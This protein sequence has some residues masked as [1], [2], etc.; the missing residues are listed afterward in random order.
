MKQCNVCGE[1]KETHLFSSCQSSK[2]KLR[3]SCKACTVK[4]TQ[5]RQKTLK[6]LVKKI[7]HNQK[8]TTG[9]MGREAPSYTEVELLN[10]ML[11]NGYEALWKVWAESGYDKWLSPSIDRIDNTKS[12]SLTNIQLVTWRKNLENQKEQNKSGKY[13][14]TKSKAVNQ[15]TLEGNYIKSFPSAAMAAREMCGRN[16]SISNITMVCAG[17]LKTAYGYLWKF[18]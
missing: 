18:A 4:A 11:E 6:G 13:L 1:F 5:A 9:K 15:Y 7:F 3:P 10:W 2:D 14:H 12:Y 17:K 8:M 16:T